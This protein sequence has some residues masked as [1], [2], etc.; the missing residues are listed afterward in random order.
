M[1]DPLAVMMIVTGI[2]LLAF[3]GF[4]LVYAFFRE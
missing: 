4:I 2:L 1:G 3:V